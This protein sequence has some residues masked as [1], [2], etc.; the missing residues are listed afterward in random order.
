MID[1]ARFVVRMHLLFMVHRHGMGRDTT[2]SR[3]RGWIK[4]M[5]F[6]LRDYARHP[7]FR[8]QERLIGREEGSWMS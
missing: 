6:S 2:A 5:W 4:F 8:E 7:W 1:L 3:C